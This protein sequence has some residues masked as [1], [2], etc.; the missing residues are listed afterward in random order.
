MG[1]PGIFLEG[2]AGRQKSIRMIITDLARLFE[3]AKSQNNAKAAC[4]IGDT[5][6]FLIQS[7]L[8]GQQNELV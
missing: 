5:L 4:M 7:S 3:I 6:I 1:R 8:K 2:C